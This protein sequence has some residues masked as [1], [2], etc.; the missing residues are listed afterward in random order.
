M[1]GGSDVSG[2]DIMSRVTFVPELPPLLPVS[3]AQNNVQLTQDAP[4]C[5]QRVATVPQEPR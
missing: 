4:S 1:G 2:M 5:Y 3:F